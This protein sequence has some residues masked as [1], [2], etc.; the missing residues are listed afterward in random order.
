MRNAHVTVVSDHGREFGA[1]GG[2]KSTDDVIVFDAY[3]SMTEAEAVQ[4]AWRRIT[5]KFTWVVSAEFSHWQTR[6]TFK[7]V[8]Y[9]TDKPVPEPTPEPVLEDEI[10]FEDSD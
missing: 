7:S 4:K 5:T 8:P 3:D 9:G 2:E 10:I 1:H 6:P